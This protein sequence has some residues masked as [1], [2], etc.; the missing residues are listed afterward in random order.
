MKAILVFNYTSKYWLKF[1]KKFSLSVMGGCVQY[2]ALYKKC[3]G[4]QAMLSVDIFERALII[5]LLPACR[6]ANKSA[7]ISCRLIKYNKQG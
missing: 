3:R 1:F 4:N 5:R 6:A 2:H 7:F